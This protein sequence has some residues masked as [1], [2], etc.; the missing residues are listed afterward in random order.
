MPKGHYTRKQRPAIRVIGPSIA[1]IELTQGLH[2]LIDAEDADV[3]E[4]EKWQA[5]WRKTAHQFYAYGAIKEGERWQLRSMHGFI[6][7]IV[8]RAV[9][10]DHCNRNGL[11]NRRSNL[12]PVTAMQNQLNANTQ[13]NNLSGCK[14]VNWNARIE[15]WVARITVNG[16]RELI[17]YYRELADAMEARKRRD[18]E[19]HAEHFG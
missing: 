8:G 15:R 11:D 19:L 6:L 1:Y 12:R 13:K 10:P 18:A 14:G 9:V 2:A 16:K 17:G 5:S 4:R 7:G 3:L